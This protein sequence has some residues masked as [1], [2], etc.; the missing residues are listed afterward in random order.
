MPSSAASRHSPTG[1]LPAPPSPVRK[2]RW[3]VYA[4]PPF[5]GPEAVLAYL[6]RYTHRVA[7]SNR[8]L[9]A[10]DET[11]VTFRYKDYRRDGA[12]RQRVMTLAPTSSSAASCSTSCHA[13]STA[14]V[15]TACSPVQHA[16]PVLRVPANC[17]PSRPRPMSNCRRA[18]RSPPALSLLRRAH[19]HHRDLRALE[20]TPRATPPH[21]TNREHPP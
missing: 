15:I 11:G 10:F 20:A 21:S 2:K 19:V 16:K 13:A 6:S 17:S 14:S 12:D 1:G 4:K 5:A 18:A 3:V 8:R 9:L 7:I